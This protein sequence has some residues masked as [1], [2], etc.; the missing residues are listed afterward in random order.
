[1]LGLVLRSLK[2]WKWFV[3]LIV[4]SDGAIRYLL[5]IFGI[6]NFLLLEN[7]LVACLFRQIWSAHEVTRL[8]SA[9]YLLN[10]KRRLIFLNDDTAELPIEKLQF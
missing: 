9:L 6:F 2:F 5:G 3:F 4:S 7:G 1:L 8:I 10:L